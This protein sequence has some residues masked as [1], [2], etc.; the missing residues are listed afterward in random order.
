MQNKVIFYNQPKKGKV[1]NDE[2]VYILYCPFAL[3]TAVF[4]FYS[5]KQCFCT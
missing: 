1:E 4:S 5:C 3:Y 2:K